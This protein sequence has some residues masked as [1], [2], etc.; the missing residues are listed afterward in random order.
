MSKITPPAQKVGDNA[1][2]STAIPSHLTGWSIRIREF[3]WNE[4]V[5]NPNKKVGGKTSTPTIF[6]THQPRI[7]WSHLFFSHDL[8]LK[9]SHVWWFTMVYQHPSSI[10]SHHVPIDLSGHPNEILSETQPC[11]EP[12]WRPKT[13]SAAAEFVDLFGIVW[14]RYPWN[15]H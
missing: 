14:P 7:S 6:I 9:K 1:M 15:N 13:S 4:L 11:E 10:I 5:R 3:L 12:V 8:L 2:N